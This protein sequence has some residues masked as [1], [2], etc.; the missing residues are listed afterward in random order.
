MSP[1]RRLEVLFDELAELAGQR[2]AIDGRIVDIVAEVH[3]LVL[4]CPYHHRL[5]H[6]GGLTLRGPAEHLV[7]TDASGRQLT[8]G[9]L[10]PPTTPPPE[11]PPCPGPGGER[12]DW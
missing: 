3:N 1:A 9:S 8:A 2:N 12:A 11:V 6:R 7:V 10:A 5:H 4:L